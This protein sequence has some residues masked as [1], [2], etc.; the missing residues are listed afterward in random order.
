MARL[1]A[2]SARYKTQSEELERSEE[3]LKLEKRKLQRE[4]GVTSVILQLINCYTDFFKNQ[5][6]LVKDLRPLITVHQT[7]MLEV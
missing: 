7:L 3:E 6:Y 1:D 2:L 4:V 5:L